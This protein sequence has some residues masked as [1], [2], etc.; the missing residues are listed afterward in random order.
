MNAHFFLPLCLAGLVHGQ[1][2]TAPPS[3]QPSQ[4]TSTTDVAPA[5]QKKPPAAG[6]LGQEIP[7]MDF[8]SETITV[9]GITIPLGDNRLLKA[10][11]EKYLNQPPETSESAAK[12]RE[13]IENILATVSPFKAG[14]PD[15][16]GA[17]KQLPSAASYPGDANLCGTLAEAVYVA[18]LSKQD[19]EGLKKLNKSIEEEKKS[20]I[21]RGDGEARHAKDKELGE[22]KDEK[23][24]KG[25]PLPAVNPG[26]GVNS[27][28]YA[29][30]LRRIAEI[31]AL[32]KLNIARTEAQI[33]RTKA[34][35]QVNMVQ[36]FMQRRYEHVLMGA[37][38]Y[39]Q[40]WKDGDATLR[41]D[42]DSDVAKLFSESMGQPHRFVARFTC[43][44]NHPRDRKIRRSLRSHAFSR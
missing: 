39:N 10:R 20:V 41:I 3:Q 15:L 8:A 7:M 27:L 29:N 37:R 30:M 19:I 24:K 6:P 5:T 43:Q 2:Y 40:I 25:K 44:R 11:F 23:G 1:V 4:A 12:Y 38:F 42:K 21:L 28:D 13:T 18:M 14:G 9:G 22:V 16:S 34:Q 31:E 26:A 17:F 36:W 35:Y 33:I 32:K